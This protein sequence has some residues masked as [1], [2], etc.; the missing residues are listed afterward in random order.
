VDAIPADMQMA[1][2]AFGRAFGLAF[3]RVFGG[4]LGPQSF[5]KRPAT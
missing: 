2:R 4:A 3:R 1:D 5:K